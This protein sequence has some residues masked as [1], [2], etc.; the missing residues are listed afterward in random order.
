MTSLVLPIFW[1][2]ISPCQSRYIVS[3]S[4][5]L[6]YF[7]SLPKSIHR[8]LEQLKNFGRQ[9]SSTAVGDCC[10]RQRKYYVGWQQRKPWCKLHVVQ[11]FRF[12]EGCKG[13]IVFHIEFKIA[14]WKCNNVKSHF[15]IHCITSVQLNIALDAVWISGVT[16]SICH[17]VICSLLRFYM[18]ITGTLILLCGWLLSMPN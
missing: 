3:W 4:V 18:K 9:R 5:S 10:V 14:E 1:R 2:G 6:T 13:S 15:V 7:F 11:T 16:A 12:L 17:P 8:F